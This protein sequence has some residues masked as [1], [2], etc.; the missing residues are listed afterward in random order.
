M[1]KYRPEK[2]TR[3]RG[4]LYFIITGV[5]SLIW[6]LIRVIPKPDRITYP[7]QRVAVANAM[8]LF[9]WLFGTMIA[10][11]V[12]K[13][14]FQRYRQANY[15][16]AVFMI[17]LALGVGVSTI[18]ISSFKEIRASVKNAQAEIFTPPEDPNQPMGVARG[19]NPGRVAW[20]HDPDAATYD[21]SAANGFWWEDKNTDPQRVDRMWDLSLDAVSGAT[22]A[23]DG[24]D[25][26]FRDANLR[27][28][29]TDIG[30]A[31]GEKIAIKANLLVGLGGGKEKANS[32]GPTPQLLMAIVSDLIDEVGIPGDKITVYDVSA[33]IPDYIMAPFSNHTDAEYQNVRFVGNPR[34]LE[35]AEA[36]R[37][38][39]AEADLD[40]A[41]HWADP[42]VADM[43]WVKSV[44]ESDYLINLTNMKGHTM[45]GVTICAKN[46]Y[47]SV[48][49]PTA[50][51]ELWTSGNYTWGFGPNNVTDSAGNPDLHRGLHR[52]AAVHEFYDGNIGDLP[53]RDYG[54]FNYMVDILGHPEIR[55]KMVLNVVDG[56]YS[57]DQQNL[58]SPWELYDGKY[59]ASIFLSQDV[60]ALESVCIDFM[61]SEPTNIRWVHGNVDNYLHEASMAHDPPSGLVYN[62]G[63]EASP[64]E[65]LGVHEHWDGWSTKRYSRNLGTGEG[66]ELYTVVF[67]PEPPTMVVAGAGD[68]EATISFNAPAN[69]GGDSISSYTVTSTPDGITANGTES[70][71][72]VSGLSNGTAYTFTVIAT[73]SAGNSIESEA[74]E[75][76]T[77]GVL[78]VPDVPTAV[79]CSLGDT[80]DAAI[81]AFTAPVSDGGAAIT[82]YTVTSNP[83]GISASGMES[84]ITVG[85][86][87][88]NTTYTF[89]VRATNEVGDSEESA[90]SNEVTTPET[91]S[92]QDQ[93]LSDV[94]VYQNTSGIVVDLRT[95]KGKQQILLFDIQGRQIHRELT[96]GGREYQMEC[97][98]ETGAYILRIQG[99]EKGF[100]QK[101]IVN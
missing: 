9:T 52:C 26:L 13:K 50:S 10:T 99:K 56:L 84:P 2:L 7:C 30:Y 27:K 42:T 18:M 92:I 3:Q 17:I 54:T 1:K 87:S 4:M 48:F 49:F 100:S 60:I 44:T 23:Y 34:Y 86:L 82:G 65:S 85:G 37:Y 59:S 94:L 72:T 70:P 78:S 81:V 40:A 62:P 22:T 88:L 38:I 31:P 53:A 75:A 15:P 66:I 74:S 80:W 55:N 5:V 79:T 46:L 24:W 16:M 32:P 51:P 43:V 58:I 19:I 57:G 83:E 73:N 14:A 8:A 6:L 71:I 28:T 41:V 20:A 25:A 91:T 47:G 39:A 101:I 12:F 68:G 93:E 29:G 89:T 36:G 45:A 90:A 11:K 96:Q 97:E 61:R 64:L 69:D 63:A 67:A 33:R 98:L 95:L 35:G 21:A 77:P 76:V